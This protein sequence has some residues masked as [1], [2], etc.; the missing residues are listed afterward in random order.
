M[1]NM[2]HDVYMH[3]INS[4]CKYDSVATRTILYK[5][6]KCN[7][8]L[9]L[10]KQRRFNKGGFAGRDYISLCDYSKKDIVNSGVSGY[11]SYNAYIKNSL[12]LIIPKKG[13]EVVEPKLVDICTNSAYGFSKML[14]LGKSKTTR[15]TDMPDEVQVKDKIALDDLIGITFPTHLLCFQDKDESKKLINVIINDLDTILNKFDKD[16][17]IYDINTELNL[18]DE[19][20]KELV[21]KELL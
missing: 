20:E 14:E 16:I 10:R 4:T 11:N 8:L 18:K 15:Y 5:I 17:P 6:L 1:N 21:L 12:S 19:V 13:L 3:A 2:N 9:S 7:A